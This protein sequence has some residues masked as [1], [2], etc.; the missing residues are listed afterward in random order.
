MLALQNVY[1]WIRRELD[2][3]DQLLASFVPH[4]AGNFA[5]TFHTSPRLSFRLSPLMDRHVLLSCNLCPGV[6]DF[7]RRSLE[8]FSARKGPGLRAAVRLLTFSLITRY[9]SM[10]MFFLYYLKNKST[11][12][13]SEAPCERVG[14]V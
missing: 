4:F 5:E 3:W 14:P 10:L 7:K 1:Q 2:Q 13:S 8:T 6:K 12:F 11:N 9:N